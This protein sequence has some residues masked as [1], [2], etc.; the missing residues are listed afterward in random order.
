MNQRVHERIVSI[1]ARELRLDA[2]Q[3]RPDSRLVTDLGAKSIDIIEVIM[4]LEEEWQ[5]DNPDYDLT[6]PPFDLLPEMT[7]RELAEVLE[8]AR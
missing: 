4:A 6:P 5:A 8:G 1:L 3:I 7:V 2:S